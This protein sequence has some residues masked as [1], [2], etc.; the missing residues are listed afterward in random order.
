MNY[1]E[2]QSQRRQDYENAKALRRGAS[3]SS[4]WMR[5]YIASLPPEQRRAAQQEQRAAEQDDQPEDQPEP[6]GIQP[7][8][9]DHG[10][11][12]ALGGFNAAQAMTGQ[13]GNHMAGMLNQTMGAINA[14]NERRVALSREMRRM[15]HEREME[16][17]RINALLQRLQAESRPSRNVDPTM[18]GFQYDDQNKRWDR[19]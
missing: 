18:M 2:R 15:E 14:E 4:Q 9:N 1:E 10:F 16:Q 12:Q 8:F 5:R 17:M 11:S 19:W 7:M 6:Q 13:Q 3:Q